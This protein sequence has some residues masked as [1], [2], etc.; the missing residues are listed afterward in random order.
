MNTLHPPKNT[1]ARQRDLTRIHKI[2]R[3]LGMSEFVYRAT[4]TETTGKDSALLMNATERRQVIDALETEAAARRPVPTI[5]HTDE[6]ALQD[7]LGW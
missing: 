1:P 5:D 6:A 2:Q 3:N 7:L 4:L